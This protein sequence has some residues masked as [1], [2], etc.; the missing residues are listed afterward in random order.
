MTMTVVFNTLAYAE[1]L[2]A[3][4]VPDEQAKAQ[5][6]ALN[7]V[8]SESSGNVLATKLDIAELKADNKMIRWMIAANSAGIAAIFGVLLKLVF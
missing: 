6:T 1:K 5:A 7:D 2:K 4:G 8:L 3:S